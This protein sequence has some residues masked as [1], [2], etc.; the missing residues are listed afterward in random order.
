MA[1]SSSRPPSDDTRPLL[2]GILIADD[3]LEGEENSNRRYGARSPPELHNGNQPEHRRAWGVRPEALQWQPWRTGAS[4]PSESDGEVGL[5]ISQGL[6]RWCHWH[7]G[8][9]NH[10]VKFGTV[11]APRTEEFSYNNT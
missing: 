3:H 6:S 11:D 10:L 8:A 5:M 9:R 4:R 1:G 2:P 7:V